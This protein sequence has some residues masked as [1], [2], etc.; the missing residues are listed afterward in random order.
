MDRFDVHFE[1]YVYEQLLPIGKI[2]AKTWVHVLAYT[3]GK[4]HDQEEYEKKLRWMI[5]G[6]PP[7]TTDMR[8]KLYTVAECIGVP[9][10]Y[11]EVNSV[12]KL[13][14]PKSFTVLGLNIVKKLRIMYNDNRI[15]FK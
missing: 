14:E 11:K 6:G 15:P 4:L 9:V 12:I 5:I 3:G 8:H 13:V 2:D 7:M 1:K 10:K